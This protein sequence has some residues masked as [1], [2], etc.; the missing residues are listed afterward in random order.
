MKP[1]IYLEWV[2][3][4]SFDPWEDINYFSDDD[5]EFLTVIKTLGFLIRESKDMFVVSLNHSYKDKEDGQEEVSCVMVIP[6][7]VVKSFQIINL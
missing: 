1:A 3:P 5:K 6:K 4:S 7:G 2:D